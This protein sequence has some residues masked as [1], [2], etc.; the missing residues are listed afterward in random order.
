MEA[1]LRN[2]AALRKRGAHLPRGRKE[3]ESV[4]EVH[5]KER[6]TQKRAAGG[7]SQSGGMVRT[8]RS[9]RDL[10]PGTT[11]SLLSRTEEGRAF[12]AWGLDKRGWQ[13]GG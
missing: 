10:K 6:E 7:D 12:A 8:E 4:Q 5:E 2:R 11:E 3:V 13:M 1:L 9:K